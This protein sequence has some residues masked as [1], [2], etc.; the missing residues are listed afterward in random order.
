[1]NHINALEL[2][3][4]ANE[5]SPSASENT[6]SDQSNGTSQSNDNSQSNEED[7]WINVT[8]GGK[9]KK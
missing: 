2:N 1:M 9:P 8:K 4:T 6:N 5:S 7:G 3:R